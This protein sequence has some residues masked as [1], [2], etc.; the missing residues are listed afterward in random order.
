MGD[1]YMKRNHLI[2]IAS[3]ILALLLAGGM[4][5]CGPSDSNTE[6]Q[7]T[8]EESTTVMG[9]ETT[10][11]TEED[12]VKK[13]INYMV[14]ADG[15]GYEADI[16]SGMAVAENGTVK[17]KSA[18]L[19]LKQAI[20]LP[21]EEDADWSIS[22]GGIM[23]PKGTG[24]G[25]IL[26]DTSEK[27]GRVYLGVN[28]TNEIMFMGIC[29]N[30]IYA[31]YCWAVPTETMKE[32]HNYQVSYS[33]GQ[34]LLSIDGGSPLSMSTMNINQANETP[35]T[36]EQASRE[37]V[38]KI[39]A[40]KGQRYV[41]MSHIGS[42][43]HPCTAELTSL[44]AK[45]S[46]ADGYQKLS[47]HPLSELTIFYLGSSIT[48]GS[49]TGGTAFPEITQKVT[50]CDTVKRAISGTNLTIQSGRTDS[51]IERFVQLPVDDDPDYLIIQ[52]SSNDFSR[53]YSLGEISQSKDL[54]DLSTATITGAIETLIAKA[55]QQWSDV[56]VV[57]Y[58][59]P[60]ETSW[61]AYNTYKTYVNGTMKALEE[62]WEGDMVMLDL[63]NSDYVRN[64][65]Y[66]HTDHLH[67]LIKGY[68]QLFTPEWINFIYEL[69]AS[70]R[71][72]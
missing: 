7:T 64:A 24:K 12:S 49:K 54:K 63:F 31:N 11:E 5:S 33:N 50:G 18:V 70:K 8:A 61:K 48:Y 65:S 34:F 20:V 15:S 30:S 4:T 67:P 22:F 69:E 9:D 6:Q 47:A 66:I 25:N 55:K 56:T 51:Y 17:M 14:I 19:Q 44:S 68:A 27:E 2:R 72:M 71:S 46:S 62:K 39:Q 3:A 57:F 60:I 52:L 42:T 58:S 1:V 29:I 59:C 36:G 45:T 43:S 10:T 40:I 38:E 53:G 26:A 41:A 35:I 21:F 23:T 37:L 16:V 28:A 13:E 32:N